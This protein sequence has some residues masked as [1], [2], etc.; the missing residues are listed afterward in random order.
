ML[1]P[2]TRCVLG[3]QDEDACCWP[4]LGS[5]VARCEELGPSKWVWHVTSNQVRHAKTIP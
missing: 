3:R 5:D 1:F 2:A 4:C